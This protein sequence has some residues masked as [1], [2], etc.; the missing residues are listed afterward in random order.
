MPY[1]GGVQLLPQTKRQTRRRSAAENK[2]IYWG[3]A[4][5]V[6][7]LVSNIILSA[8]A[9]NLSERL[10]TANG[11]LRLQ[12]DE[13]NKEHEDLLASVNQQSK[14]MGQLLTR[15]LYW[16]EAFGLIE[17][18]MQSEVRILTLSAAAADGL[19]EYTAAGTSYAAVA[20]QLS[21]F[22]SGDGVSDARL[23]SAEASAT[24]GIEFNGEIEIDVNAVL[25]RTNK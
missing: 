8:Y 22:V 9:T 16:S 24:G 14:Q 13:R 25:R 20:R 19:I 3:V 11:Q 4:L 23:M 7:V 1:Q 6:V 10:A 12:E 15:H 18:L 2:Y 5:G 17:T 21:S